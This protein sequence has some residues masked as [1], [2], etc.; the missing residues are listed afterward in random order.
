MST[1]FNNI[2]ILIRVTEEHINQFKRVCCG[3][4]DDK[5]HVPLCFP[6]CLFMSN[7]L[8]LVCRPSFKLS[9]LGKLYSQWWDNLVCVQW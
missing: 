5:D 2:S 1:I 7:V 6:E 8:L 3:Q 9:P 4:Q